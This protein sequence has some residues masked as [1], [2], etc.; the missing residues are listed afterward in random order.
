[1]LVPP[2]IEFLVGVRRRHKPRRLSIQRVHA[3]TGQQASS[4]E[5]VDIF[6]RHRTLVGRSKIWDDKEND[7]FFSMTD[8]AT[9]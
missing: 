7:V 6:P 5:M 3:F 2:F 8:E 4:T 9:A 1:M